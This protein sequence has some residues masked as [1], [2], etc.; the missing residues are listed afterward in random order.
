MSHFTVIFIS[1]YWVSRRLAGILDI[2]YT[3]SR[4]FLVN[5]THYR[6]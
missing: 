4:P 3:D 1:N 6:H 2:H 5:L